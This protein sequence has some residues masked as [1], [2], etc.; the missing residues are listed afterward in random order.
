[1]SCHKCCFDP[2]DRTSK[3]QEGTFWV[4][5]KYGTARIVIEVPESI[6]QVISKAVEKA[7]EDRSLR[8]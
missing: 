1:V 7:L 4:K 6:K 3:C 2:C 8:S 5:D